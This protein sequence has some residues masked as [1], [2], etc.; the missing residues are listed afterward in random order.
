MSIYFCVFV[1]IYSC[2]FISI[3]VSILFIFIWLFYFALVFVCVL[4]IFLSTCLVHCL[5]LLLFFNVQVLVKARKWNAV[6]QSIISLSQHSVQT[7]P[8]KIY[9][10]VKSISLFITSA[11][12][13]I[14]LSLHF[15]S[16]VHSHLQYL[17]YYIFMCTHP[18]PHETLLSNIYLF[19]SLHISHPEG[20]H[21]QLPS[22]IYIQLSL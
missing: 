17:I 7:C 20:V 14:L 18:R 6:F 16:T 1:S 8:C 2:L 9:A 22:P 15:K 13:Y 21:L 3:Y 4:S 12:I 10:P 19:K 5:F 11:H